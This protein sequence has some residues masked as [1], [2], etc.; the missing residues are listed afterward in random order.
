MVYGFLNK[1][2]GENGRKQ[3][4]T[5]WSDPEKA[6]SRLGMR[7]LWQALWG[8]TGRPR[9]NLWPNSLNLPNKHTPLLLLKLRE[10]RVQRKQWD[11]EVHKNR[12]VG[13]RV[14]RA[15]EKMCGKKLVLSWIHY[16][17]LE[18][19]WQWPAFKYGDITML[20][21]ASEISKGL[22]STLLR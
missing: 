18:E 14:T 13:E 19:P 22:H 12:Q 10:N 21:T 5:E 7:L 8:T 16:G 15:K 3:Q 9:N 20:C 17:K 11:P 1:D 2:N 4:S 6:V